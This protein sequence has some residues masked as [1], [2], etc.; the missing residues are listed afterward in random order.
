MTKNKIKTG[1]LK[2]FICLVLSITYVCLF[3]SSVFANPLNGLSL[4]GPEHLKY[5]KGQHY[6]YSNP[7]APNGGH[8]VLA[9]FGAFTKLNP[10]SLKG[11]PAPGIANLVFQTPMDSSAD[12]FEPFSQYG[13]LVEKVELADDLGLWC[14]PSRVNLKKGTEALG[15]YSYEEILAE[16]KCQ[17]DLIISTRIGHE[18][19]V[20]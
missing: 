19:I 20:K 12:D 3:F 15:S 6:E 1:C 17:L 10:A 2:Q 7:K 13:S 14:G 4:Y 8:L 5:K 9:D 18:P 16:L 11:V